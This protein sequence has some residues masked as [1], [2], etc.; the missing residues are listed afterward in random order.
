MVCY[1][2][3]PREVDEVEDSFD[4]DARLQYG[5]ECFETNSGL[6]SSVRKLADCAC[7]ERTLTLKQVE[8]VCESVVAGLQQ[9]DSS[10]I[11]IVVSC[12]PS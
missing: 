5:D 8:F 3:T 4:W 1:L 12:K 6:C 9:I 7:Q 11:G 2:P 10:G